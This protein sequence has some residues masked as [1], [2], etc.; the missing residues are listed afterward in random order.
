MVDVVNRFRSLL[1]SESP[2]SVELEIEEALDVLS[3]ERR[4]LAIKFVSEHEGEEFDLNDIV[5]YIATDQ[6]GPKFDSIQRKRVY[7]AMYQTHVDELI[8][9]GVIESVSDGDT[10]TYQV[11]GAAEPAATVLATAEDVLGVSG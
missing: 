4:R 10:H 2:E 1:G 5:R 7:V 11:G 3:N 9:A 6:Y 8:A